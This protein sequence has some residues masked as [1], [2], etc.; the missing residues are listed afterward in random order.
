VTVPL[1]ASLVAG[2]DPGVVNRVLEG[3]LV[4]DSAVDPSDDLKFERWE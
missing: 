3:D 1:S 4:I 2:L